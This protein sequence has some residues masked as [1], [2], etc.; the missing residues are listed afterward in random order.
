MGS[1]QR[2]KGV[3][4]ECEPFSPLGRHGHARAGSSVGM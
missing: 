1:M 2:R 4:G 3:A